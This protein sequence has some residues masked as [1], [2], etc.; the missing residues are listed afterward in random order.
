MRPLVAVVAIVLAIAGC[1][2]PLSA[3]LEDD[4]GL[5]DDWAVDV[6][7][8]FGLDGRVLDNA[9]SGAG[10][11]AVVW[12]SD[13]ASSVVIAYRAAP[14]RQYPR[15]GVAK[16]ADR[17]QVTIAPRNDGSEPCGGEPVVWGLGLFFTPGNGTTAIDVEMTP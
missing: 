15:V 8:S 11:P 9:T 2:D 3:A 14:C 13:D 7:D 4:T 12:S 1:G 17:L 10:L 6:L 5:V 16:P